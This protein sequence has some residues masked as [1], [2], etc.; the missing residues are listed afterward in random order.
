MSS[1]EGKF[2]FYYLFFSIYRK[3]WNF[4]FVNEIWRL[5]FLYDYEN[6]YRW[7]LAIWGINSEIFD[8]WFWKKKKWCGSGFPEGFLDPSLLNASPFLGHMPF[9]RFP[10][11]S[12]LHRDQ[13]HL[14]RIYSNPWYTI[15]TFNLEKCSITLPGHGKSVFFK[16]RPKYQ[17]LKWKKVMP[18]LGM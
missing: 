3:D 8:T 11:F 13:T 5:E 18:S 9:G 12:F 14:I 4:L 2:F 16:Y 1:F 10:F 6:N 15:C 7:S 17:M